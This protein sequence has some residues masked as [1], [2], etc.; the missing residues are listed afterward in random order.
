MNIWLYAL[1]GGSTHQ[2]TQGPGGDFQPNWSPDGTRIA[3]F[4]SRAGNVDIWTVEVETGKLAQLT[5]TP[6]ID[7][8]PFFS[9]DG[10]RIAYQSDQSGR[11]EVWVMNADGS[12][13]RQLSRVGAM[14][15]FLR[16]TADGQAVV[17]TCRCG[18][19]PQV[20]QVP[21]NGGDPHLLATIAGG[22]HLS[23]APDHSQIMDVVG[24]KTLWVTPVKGGKPEKVF[25]FDDPDVRID[26]PVWSPDGRWVLFDRFRPQGGDI[27]VIQDFE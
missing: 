4:S 22:S 23:F 15:H 3:F 17:F 6:A 5:H 12:G 8:N 7:V 10:S 1:T 20:F 14:G 25:A 11:L 19:T 16:W 18:G 13:A 2:L 26:Y 24:H 21:L 9:P 27:W